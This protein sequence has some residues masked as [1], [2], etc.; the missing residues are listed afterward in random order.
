[1]VVSIDA[2]GAGELAADGDNLRRARIRAASAIL[3]VLAP[4][5]PANALD[6]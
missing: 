1:M 2:E 4:R 6:R 5:E 3:L